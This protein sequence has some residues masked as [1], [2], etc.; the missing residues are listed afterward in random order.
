MKR[1]TALL[2][3]ALLC[4]SLVSCIGEGEA[5]TE[6]QTS[7]EVT[8]AEEVGIDLSEYTMIRPEK[9]S[10]LANG[11]ASNLR[12][13][14]KELGLQIDLKEDW[15]QEKNYDSPEVAQLKE[16]LIGSTNRPESALET[17]LEYS[18]IAISVKGNK[19]LIQAGSDIALEH[20]CAEFLKHLRAA[21]GKVL[22]NIKDDI[23]LDLELPEYVNTYIVAD[24]KASK[25]RFYGINAADLST[26][27]EIKSFEFERNNIAGLKLRNFEG[28]QVLIA[29]YGSR[30]G[31]VIDIA[32]GEVMFIT[33]EAGQNPH[34][35]ELTPNG[36]FCIASSNG[37]VV[38]FFNVKDATKQA[39]VALPDAHGALYDPDTGLV[40]AVG[41]N[42]LRAFKVELGADGVPVV[43]E[44]KS[45]AFTLP[46]N[47]AHDLS[48][49]SGNT[50]LFWI[51]TTSAVYQYSVSE[52][53][54]I[55]GYDG[56]KQV[57][58]KN[59]KGIG[60]FADG[61]LIYITPDGKFESW[62]S[63]TVAYFHH[64]NGKYYKYSIGTSENGIYKVR[65]EN[66][67]YQ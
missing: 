20:A 32:T 25:V 38:K 54:I 34:S 39:E 60:N 35:P 22:F 56:E 46:S 64:F 59:V 31:K 58:V 51:T 16:I 3:A 40:F 52:K 57:N 44:D 66:Y 50:D 28:K 37:S 1:L 55:A 48:P 53:K 67:D 17:P 47:Y 49:V 21:D 2:L 12:G 13:E 62:T 19:I 6:P 42:R 9:A 23:K 63:E 7:E 8:A 14:L 24:Q 4:L 45:R 10:A 43:T 33:N 41:E 26:A 18:Q 29:A 27:T 11:I 15:L 36:V 5:T 30:Y 65:P 61:S